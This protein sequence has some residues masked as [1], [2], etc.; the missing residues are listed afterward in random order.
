M[1]TVDPT[2]RILLSPE[3]V[4]A[5]M[6]VRLKCCGSVPVR[7]GCSVGHR[8]S[9]SNRHTRYPANTKLQPTRLTTLRVA[10]SHPGA[11]EEILGNC[12]RTRGCTSTAFRSNSRVRPKVMSPLV[13][14]GRVEWVTG[15]SGIH[16][17]R[18]QR[19][20]FPAKGVFVPIV[21]I[22]TLVQ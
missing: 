1:I 13:K 10:F 20:G 22:L 19:E 11:N 12:L 3:F 8:G 15:C 18:E 7:S 4:S 21:T 9:R 17:Q 5:A 16:C 14:T 6:R 2:C